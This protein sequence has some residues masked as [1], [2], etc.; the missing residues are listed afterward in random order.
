[1]QRSEAARQLPDEQERRFLM[2]IGSAVYVIDE[3]MRKNPDHEAI[4][5]EFVD[6]QIFTPD[7][8]VLGGYCMALAGALIYW[9][10]STSIPAATE[11]QFNTAADTIGVEIIQRP[12]KKV[13]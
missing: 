3:P 1:M 9:G 7:A 10:Q 5:A 12:S 4:A 13:P 6:N 2:T 8:N 11:D